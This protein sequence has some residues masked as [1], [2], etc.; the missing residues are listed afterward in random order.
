[1]VGTGIKAAAQLTQE[2]L[3]HIKND[4]HVMYLVADPVTRAYILELNPGAESLHVFFEQGKPRYASYE[5]IVEH[6]LN[7]LRKGLN[8]CVAFYGHPGI[9]VYPSH[10]L[11][12]RAAGEGFKAVMLPGI[13][14]EDCLFADLGFDPGRDGVQSFEA[15]DFLIYEHIPDTKALLVLWQI[16]VIGELAHLGMESRSKGLSVM[17]DRLMEFYPAS[18]LATLYEASQFAGFEYLKAEC[19]LQELTGAQ[20]SP[21]STL[22]VPACQP[23]TAS[24]EVLKKLNMAAPRPRPYKEH[25]QPGIQPRE[26]YHAC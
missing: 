14:A 17:R 13:S 16:G 12:R 10:E 24:P 15:T 8:T 5:A 26:G 7:F 2:A 25:S 6:A 1:M 20:V 22:V 23:C 4:D 18:H 19:Q 9:F 3:F 21:F 11:V